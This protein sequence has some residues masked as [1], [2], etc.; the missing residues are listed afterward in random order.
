MSA[1]SINN[2]EKAELEA[3]ASISNL[4][5]NI[6][7][8]S[9][10][11]D[12]LLST[13]KSPKLLVR[14]LTQLRDLVEMVD[15]KH[16]I[17][18]QIKFIIINQARKRKAPSTDTSPPRKRSRHERSSKGISS[19]VRRLPRQGKKDDGDYES[20]CQSVTEEKDVAD[21]AKFEGHMLHS[22]ISGNPGTGKT[23]VAMILAKIWMALGFVSKK[24]PSH[25]ETDYDDAKRL[26]EN[27]RKSQLHLRELR[28]LLDKH[29]EV[30]ND[31]KCKVNNLYP[32]PDRPYITTENQ[33]K[34][35][36]LRCDV[37]E[38]KYGYDDVLKKANAGY[39]KPP[40]KVN[41][42]SDPYEDVDPKFIVAARE[43]L[44]ARYLGQT[45]PKTKKV[46][47]SALGGVLFIDEAYSLCNMDGNSKDRFGDECLTTINEFMSLHSEEII[48]IFAGYK[49]KMMETIFR[50]QPGLLRR[51]TWTFEIKDYTPQGLAKILKQQLSN[52]GWNI[53]PDV[54]IP[55][56]LAES[57][58]IIRDGGGGT[59]K[60]AFFCK[61]EYGD[62]KFLETVNSTPEKII[63]HD[64][65]I[66]DKMIQAAL[67]NMKKNIDNHSSP[68]KLPDMYT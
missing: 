37:R 25:P 36:S 24:E 42:N 32:V 1:A 40:G 53:S 28:K 57:K 23:T 15:I 35:D 61:I 67:I 54:N 45:A 11:R 51:C 49:D 41:D 47:E 31:V 18:S 55:K 68:D 64:S 29:G 63:R 38:L 44:V 43:D 52:K 56:I 20:D 16:S 13:I 58:D 4:I 8:L 17:V 14:G 30:V 65:M 48:L 27:K 19:R 7:T 59:E 60:L 34:W 9:A 50:S 2:I 5:E 12:S 21:N 22:V 26:E 66:T 33:R 3:N 6:N 62:S 39:D 46:L 10:R